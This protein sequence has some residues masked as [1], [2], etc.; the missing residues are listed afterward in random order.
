M[1]CSK[2]IGRRPLAKALS[3]ALMGSL[4]MAT[5]ARAEAPPTPTPAETR[6]RTDVGF[7]AADAREG[8]SPGSGGIEAAADYIAATF[9]NAGLKPAAG[10]DGYFQTFTLGGTPKLGNDAS[11]VINVSA[12]S[13][14]KAEKGEF[15][16]LAA[17][18]GGTL[19][20]LPLVFVG[21]GITAKDDATKLD[22]DD[23][24]GLDVK[25]KA[26][27][28][29]RK[30]PL[31]GEK[32]GLFGGANLMRFGSFRHKATN[33]FQ[34]GAAAVILVNDAVSV[35]DGG[36][37]LL[38]FP[39]A[40]TDVLSNVPFG[41]VTRAFADKILAATKA[42][43][44]EELEKTLDEGGK[45]ASRVLEGAT[46]D[47]SFPIE[48]KSVGTKNVIGVLEGSGPLADETIVVGGHYDHL[49]HGG[50]LSG[51]LAFL[52]S[53]IHNGADDNASGTAMVM[54]LARRLGRRTDPLPRRVVFMAFSGEERGLLGSQH[55]VENPLY[56]LD[57]TVMMINFDMVGRMAKDEVTFFG[58]GSTPGLDGLV[59]AI[60]SSAGI[61]VKKVAGMSDG[62]GGSDHQSFYQ[63]DIPVLF[64]FT[65]TH[66]DY[67]RPT[68][69]TEHINF[70]GM[71]RIANLGELLLLD[72]TRRPKRP[73]FVKSA[74]ADHGAG[75][76]DP[77]RLSVTVYLGTMP[78][79]ADGTKGVKLAGVREGS[80]AEKGGLQ[81]GDIIIEFGG[82]PIGTINDYME[83][84]G[85]YKP[86]DEVV[87]KV[88][89]GEKDV[90]L[91]VKLGKRPSQ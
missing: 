10:A 74:A 6:M 77:A 69:D 43:K 41:M 49:G 39:A 86:D 61:T 25:G 57:K 63:K 31:Q 79:Y 91:K 33:A 23:Y 8:R 68:D 72:F 12:D 51:S 20:K 35:K 84:M 38:K 32:D 80:P 81:G 62:F 14:L 21:Y 15:T 82:K 64:A 53:D 22:Y 78:D 50:L 47:G 7:L 76:A 16:P 11:L 54:E 59:D 44:L 70:E 30:T 48:R 4:A 2:R 55:Y 56:P 40:G 90:D 85:R 17:G 26:I 71:G 73:E 3:M 37:E 65:G 83:S 75:G 29:I 66:K 36:D 9:M 89:R 67:H 45:P 87:I 42:P 34:H 19:A 60:G 5:A 27:L 18:V 58:V 1:V 52:S 46:V 28:I 13:S 24:A 88:K